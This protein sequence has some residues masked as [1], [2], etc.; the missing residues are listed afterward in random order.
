MQKYPEVLIENYPGKGDQALQKMEGKN[1]QK[2]GMGND[3]EFTQA[4]CK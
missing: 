3:K 4:R 1:D 2:G